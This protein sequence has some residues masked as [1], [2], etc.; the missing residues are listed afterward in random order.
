MSANPLTPH[1]SRPAL[2]PGQPVLVN[3]HA[4][5][6]VPGTVV[7]VAHRAIGIDLATNRGTLRQHV[8]P[9]LVV[10]AGTLRRVGEVREGDQVTGTDGTLRTV[11]AAPWHG[12]D[13]WWVLTY[14]GGKTVAL[15]PGAMLRVA[16]PAAT[17]GS[18]RPA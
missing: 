7:S 14:D 2:T 4:S 8:Q 15:P 16:D 3:T 1:L 9:W 6:W 17:F 11:A 5:A 18:I 13:G 10:P 12:A